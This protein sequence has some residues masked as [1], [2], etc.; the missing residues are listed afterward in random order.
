MPEGDTL[1]RT[2][3]GLRPYLVGR[4]VT[5]ASARH[6]AAGERAGGLDRDRRRGAWARTS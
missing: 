4:P 5:A 2:A 6:R 3:A 1:F